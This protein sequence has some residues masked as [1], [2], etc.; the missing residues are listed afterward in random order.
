LATLHEQSDTLFPPPHGENAAASGHGVSNYNHQ[1]GI[2][3]SVAETDARLMKAKMETPK[4]RTG[5][6]AMGNARRGSFVWQTQQRIPKKFLK[7][8]GFPRPR[9]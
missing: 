5:V 4:G 7:K 3:C 2:L 9:P 8:Q 6:D 1:A